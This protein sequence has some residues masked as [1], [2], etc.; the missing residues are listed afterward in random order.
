MLTFA[1]KLLS[2]MLA[3]PKVI[4]IY[5]AHCGWCFGFKNSIS[6]LYEKY[7]NSIEFEVLSGN[8]MPIENRQHI[9]VMAGYIADAYKRVEDLT[10]CKFGDK[11]LEHILHPENSQLMLSSEKP[12]IALSV[13]KTFQTGKDLHFAAAL[14]DKIMIE[15][16]DLETDMPYLELAA[17]FN[18]DGPNFVEKLGSEDSRDLAHSEFALVKQLG[19]TGFPCVLVQFDERKLYMIA[20]GYTAPDELESRLLK[21]LE[22]FRIANN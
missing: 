2:N 10:G 9:S 14:Q 18:F 12:G 21:V 15:G 4:Y 5:D 20:K 1:R 3:Y 17:Q 11:Y 13:F 8:M 16:Q 7:G 19:I 22:E 6:R